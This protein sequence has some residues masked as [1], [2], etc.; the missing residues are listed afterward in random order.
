M[1]SYRRQVDLN[2]FNSLIAILVLVLFFVGMYYI[3]RSIFWVLSWLAPVML[4]A[5]LILDY[6]VVTGYFKWLWRT[7]NRTPLLGI[8]A[9]A[10][11]VFGYPVISG[12]L[13]V[14]ALLNRQ[15]RRMREEQP[16]HPPENPQIGEYIDYEEIRREEIE[17]RERREQRGDNE[18]DNLFQ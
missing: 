7:L 11:T 15:V 16:E 12:F 10:L 6:R 1:P 9:I 3:A 13:L 5:T 2:P 4:I 14:K 18:Y 17:Y 8:G